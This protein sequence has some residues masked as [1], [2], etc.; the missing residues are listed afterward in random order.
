MLYSPM[1]AFVRLPCSSWKSTRPKYGRGLAFLYC[2]IRA[3]RCS[4]S[5]L[6]AA[7]ERAPGK[8]NAAAPP[9]TETVACPVPVDTERCTFYPTQMFESTRARLAVGS[10]RFGAGRSIGLL[11]TARHV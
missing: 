2:A 1:Y 3:S 4:L 8:D 11:G 5:F 10:F 6:A 7:V 9:K